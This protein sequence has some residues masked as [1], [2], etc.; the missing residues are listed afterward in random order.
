MS[1]ECKT[2]ATQGAARTG[3]TNAEKSWTP[4][5]YE[6]VG[7]GRHVDHATLP[8]QRLSEPRELVNGRWAVVADHPS[9]KGERIAEADIKDKDLP[10]QAQ[11]APK[12]GK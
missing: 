11:A 6:N 8:P 9:M 12:G 10:A 4:P 2:Y 5:T 7:G 1:I 3:I